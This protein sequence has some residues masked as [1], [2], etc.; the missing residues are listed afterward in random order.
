VTLRVRP[1]NRLCLSSAASRNCRRGTIPQ[2][3]FTVVFEHRSGVVTAQRNGE[4]TRR[5]RNPSYP[6]YQ[7]TVPLF[8]GVITYGRTLEEAREMARGASAVTWKVSV[9]TVSPSQRKE[10]SQRKAA[11]R[12]DCLDVI[13][14]A[15]FE[16]KESCVPC[17]S[18]NSRFIIK[19][20]AT[21]TCVIPPSLA[22]E[23][24]FPDT[25]VSIF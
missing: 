13:S 10:G 17:S 4:K 8:P 18:P 7:L 19:P 14:F 5:A 12:A 3:S 16:A 23:S 20:A 15:C 9:R 2:Y 24:L 1:A 21:L 25:T 22:G 11:R 6:G